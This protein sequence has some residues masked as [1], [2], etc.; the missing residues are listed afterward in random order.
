[1]DKN[2]FTTNILSAIFEVIQKP[3]KFLRIT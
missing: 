3:L 2:D 1:M